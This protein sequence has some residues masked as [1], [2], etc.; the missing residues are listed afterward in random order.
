MLWLWFYTLCLK[1]ARKGTNYLGLS[2][3]VRMAADS[4]SVSIQTLHAVYETGKPGGR[5]RAKS[6]TQTTRKGQRGCGIEL[7][8]IVLGLMC[9]GGLCGGG[10]SQNEAKSRRFGMDMPCRAFY[11][12][13]N[14][15]TILNNCHK[16]TIR[17]SGSSRRYTS[18]KQ[19]RKSAGALQTFEVHGLAGI[20]PSPGFRRA[21]GAPTSLFARRGGPCKALL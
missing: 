8:K 10:K 7:F 19:G 14:P 18:G 12:G 21:G 20:P 5:N 16:S 13:V 3:S 17:H 6:A 15:K 4:A 9:P 11:E 1:I 2:A